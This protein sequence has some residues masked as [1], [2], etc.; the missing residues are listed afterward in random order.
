MSRATC[1]PTQYCCTA[2]GPLM[3]TNRCLCPIT[4]GASAQ[5]SAL[6]CTV[7]EHIMLGKSGRLLL[8][9]VDAV[10]SV[11]QVQ[12]GVAGDG[13]RPSPR[14]VQGLAEGTDAQTRAGMHTSSSSAPAVHACKH[15]VPPPAA[16]AQI[17][18][19]CKFATLILRYKRQTHLD[20]SC[21]SPAG[22]LHICTPT[23]NNALLLYPYQRRLAAEACS[24]QSMQPESV[25]PTLC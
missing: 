21:I 1:S 9:N 20:V 17:W 19:D 11:R 6:L 14:P 12:V 24:C 8:R 23:P 7:A 2:L 15:M 22:G 18:S 4:A 5:A 10:G 13:T 3:L 25:A 16:F